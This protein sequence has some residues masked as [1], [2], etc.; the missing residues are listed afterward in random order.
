[1]SVLGA[2]RAGL[3]SVVRWPNRAVRW[4]IMAPYGAFAVLLAISATFAA[5]RLVTG[6]LEQRFEQQLAESARVASDAVVRRERQH[7]AVLRGIAFSDGIDTS[8]GASDRERLTDL[9]QP[10]VA[11]AKAEIVEL[12]DAGGGPL[13]GLVLADAASLRYTPIADQTDRRGWPI[14]ELVLSRKVDELGDKYAQ[15]VETPRGYALYTAGP[16]VRDDRFLG[17]VLVGSL[18]QSFLPVAKAEAAAD[19]SVYGFNGEPL[20]TTFAEGEAGEVDLR[21][22]HAAADGPPVGHRERKRLYGREYELLYGE[23]VIRQAALGRFSVA[24]PSS[25]IA[26]AGGATGWRM[27][28]LFAFATLGVLLIGWAIAR[29]VSRPLLRLASTARRVAAGDLSARSGVTGDDEV[30]LLAETFDQMTERV[31]R[32][33]FSTVKALTSAID[34]RDP[35]TAG[36]SA[37]VGQLAVELGRVLQLPE[38]DL[39]H[40]EIGGYLHDIGKIGIRDAVLL[41]PEQLTPEERE[42]IEAH[43]RIGMDILASVELP[44]QVLDFVSGHHEKLNGTGYPRGLRAEQISVVARIAAVADIYDALTT[45]RPYRAAMDVRSAL[46]V[47][48]N[49]AGA[50][51]LDNE[52][53]AAL[54]GTAL[55]WERRV[56]MDPTLRGFRLIDRTLQR[57]G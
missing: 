54:K 6:S 20:A 39:Q 15:I 47:L 44:V 23:L 7:L 4:K 36:H 35:Y 18:L 51:E 38:S 12:L 3:P 53:V 25:F 11:N 16:I 22:A 13:L 52:V 32:Q 42:L 26:S 50:G 8:L 2:F 19:V 41:K 55:R 40:L 56:R 33:H 57:T 17:V 9:V 5:V 29:T 27:S 28:L 10:V 31:Q 30:G 43:P 49:W 46:D 45:D 1:M 21:P 24:L 48:K 34:A 37:R 14:V